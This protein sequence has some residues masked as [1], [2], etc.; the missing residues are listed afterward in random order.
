MTYDATPAAAAITSVATLQVAGT[1]EAGSTVAVYDG[2]LLLGRATASATGNWSVLTLLF[3]TVH[4]MTATVT[5]R[6]GNP[7]PGSAPTLV[8]SSRADTLLGTAAGDTLLGNGGNDVLEGGAGND[9]LTGGSGAD[10]FLMRAGS[11]HDIV[12]DFAAGGF[13][14]D[15]LRLLGYGLTSFDAVMARTVQSGTSTV[16]TLDAADSVTLLNL[17]KAS[18]VAND[19]L[20]A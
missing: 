7:G 12:T 20:F 5:D 18:L 14:H 3:D 15:A 1:A 19:F 17:S 4:S 2:S 13:F 10:T 16:I 9:R 8:G 11:G 6:A